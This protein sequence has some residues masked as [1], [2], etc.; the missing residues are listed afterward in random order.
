VHAGALCAILA[1]VCTEQQRAFDQH[2]KSTV[3]INMDGTSN[4]RLTACATVQ[5]VFE[6]FG[7]L[8]NK[9]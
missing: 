8:L 1:V 9:F 7:A 6:N 3:G 4:S 5:V 2:S